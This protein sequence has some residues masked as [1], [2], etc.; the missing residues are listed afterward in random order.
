LSAVFGITSDED[1]D[2]NVATHTQAPQRGQQRR[3]T[4]PKQQ[5]GGITPEQKNTLGTAVQAASV[6]TGIDQKRVYSDALNSC[7]IPA[8]SSEML[9]KDEADKIIQFLGEF[10]G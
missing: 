9:T 1:D 2:G 8:K 7:K 3:Q 6:K 4:P 10:S 5:G